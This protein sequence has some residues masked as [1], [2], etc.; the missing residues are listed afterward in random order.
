MKNVFP[1][2]KKEKCYITYILPIYYLC[3]T[4]ILPITLL[5]HFQ[6]PSG[7][8]DKVLLQFCATSNVMN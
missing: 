8:R 1:Q 3:S 2:K 5:G 6:M 7:P 4:Y